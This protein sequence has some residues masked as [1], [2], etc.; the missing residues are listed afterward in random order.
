M[1]IGMP[2]VAPATTEIVTIVKNGVNGYVD[3]N[4][5]AL[6]EAMEALLHDRDLAMKWGQGA[7][8]TALERF[9]I[10]RFVADWM[11]VLADVA[12][13]QQADRAAA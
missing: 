10:D 9:N 13:T 2:I 12:R 1:M 4:R 8:E 5:K 11:A 6:M 3:T 7:R